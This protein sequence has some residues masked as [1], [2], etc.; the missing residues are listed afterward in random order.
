MN[1]RRVISNL[2]FL[3]MLGT[4]A[5]HPATP[6]L[7]PFA[8]PAVSESILERPQNSLS[9]IATPTASSLDTPIALSPTPQSCDRPLPLTISA[10]PSLSL[11][12]ESL[13]NAEYFDAN[14]QQWIKL[15][16]GVFDSGN[17][18][19]KIEGQP[20]FGNLDGDNAIDNV[21][22]LQDWHGGTGRFR[23]IVAV[24]NRNGK[25]FQIA[26]VSLYDRTQVEKVT[27]EDGD[28][29]LNLI[30]HKPSDGLC[31]PSQKAL[32]IFRLCGDQLIRIYASVEDR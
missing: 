6:A 28:I 10:S 9:V 11:T 14:D 27:V 5:C 8:S 19:I 13:E 31:C 2:Y 21:V 26:S 22:V 20:A 4:T 12:I 15:S 3:A 30:V 29:I 24:L 7:Q 17:I 25:P 1:C 18:H 16:Q 32:W 23:S